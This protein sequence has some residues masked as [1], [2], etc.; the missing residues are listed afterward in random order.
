MRTCGSHWRSHTRQRHVRARARGGR[1]Q[2]PQRTGRDRYHWTST[3]PGRDGRRCGV[4]GRGTTWV[5][6][7]VSGRGEVARVRAALEMREVVDTEVVPVLLGVR[8]CCGASLVQCGL[9]AL[10]L[11]LLVEPLA[12]EPR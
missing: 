9:S 8:A 1:S 5:P 10:L 11:G 3:R 4:R 7:D 2:R 6:P 12:H